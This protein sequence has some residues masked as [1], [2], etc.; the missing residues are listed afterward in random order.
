M[1]DG[2]GLAESGGNLVIAAIEIN[3]MVVV[4]ATLRAQGEVEIE[5]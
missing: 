1:D 3:G 4:D 2:N 5:E